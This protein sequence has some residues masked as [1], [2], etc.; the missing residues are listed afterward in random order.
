MAQELNIS[1][2]YTSY[3]LFKASALLFNEGLKPVY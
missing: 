1:L 2:S 3:S